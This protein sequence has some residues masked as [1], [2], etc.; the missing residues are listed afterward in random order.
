MVKIRAGIWYRLCSPVWKRAVRSR[1]TNW[2]FFNV[3]ELFV[4]L[5]IVPVRVLDVDGVRLLRHGD[6]EMEDLIRVSEP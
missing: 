2:S 5:Y 4:V 3:I 6:Q 1:A